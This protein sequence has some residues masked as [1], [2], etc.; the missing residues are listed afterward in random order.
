MS[1]GTG[2]GQSLRSTT[3][4]RIDPRVILASQIL[5]LNQAELSEAVESELNENPALDRIDDHEEG[6]TRD[7]IMRHVAPSELKPSGECHELWR[8]L[9]KDAGSDF[10]WVEMASIK[11]SLWD[12]LRA[13]LSHKLPGQCGAL[14]EYLVGSINERGYLTCTPEEAALD[15]DTSLEEAE[16]AIEALKS[17]E[18]AGVGASDL[19][20]CLYLQMRGAESDAEKLARLILKNQWEELVQRDARSIRRAYKVPME[21]VEEAFEVIVSLSPFPGE[22]F[23]VSS[24]SS[25]E[26]VVG[27]QPDIA[28]KRDEA[29]WRVDVQG[30][31]PLSLR[32]DRTY[33]QRYRELE[34]SR[35]DKG[36]KRHISEFV[37]RAQAFLDAVSQ[38][39][40]LMAEIGKYL[41]D[42]QTGFVSTGEYRFLVPLTRS[43]VAQ[44]LGAHE[45]TVS[46]ATNGKYVEIA[47]G[48]VVSFDVFFK[49]AL[50]VQK[51]IEEILA[52][53]NPD[54]PLSDESI[55]RLLKEQGV[56]VARRTVNKYRDRTKLL[57]SRRRKSA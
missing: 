27:A 55:A 15:C 33:E 49:P 26:R 3:S 57:S 39:R 20:E 10:D 53:E 45:S 21:L 37:E 46:R 35:S 29:G 36:E 43:Q 28:L 48:E 54:S 24:A 50:R 41:I 6:P 8:S 1:R 9:P 40:R 32:I 18:P 30:P 25:T 12:H 38:R 16:M 5:E 4:L 19:Q 56:Q 7:E 31:S 44:D 11:S 52:S 2:F 42:R 22:G 14:C 23:E 13:Q 51:L 47:T 17:C 34:K